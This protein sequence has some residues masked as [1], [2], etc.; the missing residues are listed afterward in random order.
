[1]SSNIFSDFATF[2][3]EKVFGNVTTYSNIQ[4]SFMWQLDYQSKCNKSEIG[5]K[6][7]RNELKFFSF[8]FM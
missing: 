8:I 1:M 3:C 5:L 4:E 7:Y 2:V 6:T